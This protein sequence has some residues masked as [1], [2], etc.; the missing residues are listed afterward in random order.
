MVITELHGVG[1]STGFLTVRGGDECLRGS[2]QFTLFSCSAAGESGGV[3]SNALFPKGRDGVLAS[4]V[5]TGSVPT[6]AAEA[7]PGSSCF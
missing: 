6:E 2:T 3:S 5:Q 4:S 7:A 1:D